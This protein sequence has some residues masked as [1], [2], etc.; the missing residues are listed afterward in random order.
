MKIEFELED[1]L[2]KRVDALLKRGSYKNID[3]FM[4]RAA[5]T[6][7]MAEERVGMFQIPLKNKLNK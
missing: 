4:N 7:L 5:E 2:K 1:R 3:E 6:L